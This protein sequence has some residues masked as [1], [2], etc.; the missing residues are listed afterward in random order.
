MAQAGLLA[1]LLTGA[2]YGGLS[3]RAVT[4]DCVAIA[5]FAVGQ[6]LFAWV[7]EAWTEAAARRTRAAVRRQ[8]LAA[9][10]DPMSPI[11]ALGPGGV[12]TLIGSEAD[13][14]DPFVARVL[15]RAV[16]T[17]AVP[18]PAAGLDRP[19]GPSLACPGR[20]DAGH[21]AGPGLA[22]RGGHL[23]RGPAPAGQPRAPRRPI[24]RAGRGAAAAPGLRP[25]RRPRAG[26]GGFGRAGPH[27]HAG[28]LADRAA[29]RA[30]RVRL[31][32]ARPALGWVPQHPAVLP[33][34]V[35]ENIAGQLSID[36]PTRG[37]AHPRRSGRCWP[38]VPSSRRFSPPRCAR[39][40]A[41]AP[42]HAA[43]RQITDLLRQFRLGPWLD[44]LE[45]G[46]GTVLA[47]WDHPVSGGE[48][49]RLS[50][51]R[52]VLAGRPAGPASGRTHQA[53]RRGHGRRCAPRGAGARG[54]PVAAVDHPPPGRAGL[55]P[56]GS[57]PHR[58]PAECIESAA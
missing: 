22:C 43:D 4:G 52:A 56:G 23:G 21:R 33:A 39:T 44:R 38:G 24:R 17:L 53:P 58:G 2:F 19:S 14:L 11:D 30:G 6:A 50:V 57:P 47:P 49:Q 16:L 40:C 25:G 18:A 41:S 7:W 10:L 9:A 51:A 27:G 31:E 5:S 13:E 3:G 20:R 34:T 37:P 54:G 35:L 32:G 15:P 36:A 12:T 1:R 42:R 45:Q 28:H 26:R 55:V 8:A 46:L 48:L 29:R